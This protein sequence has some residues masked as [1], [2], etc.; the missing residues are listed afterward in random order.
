MLAWML[1]AIVVSLLL[2]G[3]AFAAERSALIGRAPTRWLWAAGILGSLVL[4][5]VIS[6]VSIQL[7]GLAGAAGP[8]APPPPFALRQITA[9]AIQPSD[10]LAA[11]IGP[12]GEAPALDAVL[13]RGWIAAS[14]LILVAILAAGAMLWRRQRAWERRTLAGTA[15]YVSEDIGPA[16]VGLLRPRIVLPRWIAEAPGETQGMV[17]A[18]E[19][20]HLQAG[21]AQLL[22]LAILLIAAMP[23]N[24]PLWWQLRRLRLAIEMD[25]DARVLKG[26]CDVALYGE[27]LLMVG[28]RQ[29][30][31]IAVVAAMSEP[32]SFLEQRIRNML[33]KPTRL[34]WAATAALASLAFVLAAAAAEV[35]PPDVAAPRPTPAAAEPDAAVP[36]P[37]RTAVPARIDPARVQI[38]LVDE[39]P[40]AAGKAVDE[41]VV[42]PDGSE[43]WLVPGA[44]IT[45]RMFASAR[46]G[47]D[48]AGRPLVS[49]VLTPEGSARF[50]ELTRE[51]T[52]RRLA[53][54]VDGK[55]VSAPVVRAEIAGG[56]GQISGRFTPI[57]TEALARQINA[58][59][60]A[61]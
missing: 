47:Q 26:G 29:S 59:I 35:R 54:L 5:L 3:A 44:P 20:A 17:L 37:P 30:R 7:P 41:R 53:I 13:L 15:V 21:D 43:L 33:R 57:E 8:L 51:N 50:S 48:D 23:W 42:G 11:T 49:F 28:E 18:H 36:A 12:A 6:T 60:P 55:V 32:K 56:Q 40:D 58:A 45:G 25:C 9:G 22:A 39:A 27:T 1:Y 34:A 61:R 38:R 4:P 24:L 31:R 52:G 19:R 14:A 10:W 46:A 16:V 2:A